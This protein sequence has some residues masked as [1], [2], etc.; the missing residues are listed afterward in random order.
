MRPE[1]IEN[2]HECFRRCNYQK[3]Y[4]A[5]VDNMKTAERKT[6]VHDYVVGEMC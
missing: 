5:T 2:E 4:S 6:P 3:P 1:P